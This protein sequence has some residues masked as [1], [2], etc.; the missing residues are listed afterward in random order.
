MPLAPWADGSDGA[1][2]LCALEG[3]SIWDALR[4]VTAAHLGRLRRLRDCK[5]VR[6]TRM[7]ITSDRP[8]MYQ[9]DGDPAGWLPVE[10]EVVPCRVTLVVP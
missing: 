5:V 9:L 10:I 2:D 7:R 6:A 8:V 3:R 1:L 4:Y